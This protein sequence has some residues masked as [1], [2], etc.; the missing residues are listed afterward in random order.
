MKDLYWWFT[1]VSVETLKSRL[2]EAGPGARLE[3][4]IG[5]DKKMT[6]RVIAAGAAKAAVEE[7]I[8]ES[9]LCPPACP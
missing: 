3:V 8:N 4:R 9:W 5:R 6:F 1:G 7:D 2:A